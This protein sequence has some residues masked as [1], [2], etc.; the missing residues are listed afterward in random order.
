[1]ELGKHC[2]SKSSNQKENIMKKQLCLLILCLPFLTMAQ[3]PDE[4]KAEGGIKWTTGLSWEQI[5]QKAKAENKYIF[6]DAYTTW[7]GPCKMMDKYVYPNDTVSSF[8]NEHF[9][10]VKAQ[11]DVTEKDDQGIRDWY[12]DS[13]KI[14]RDYTVTA[15]PS[16]IFL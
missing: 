3:T 10:A 14:E 1:V 13:K 5:K 12:T 15:Y 16:L 8:F 9:V 7:C 4:N 11:M 2:P 6:I